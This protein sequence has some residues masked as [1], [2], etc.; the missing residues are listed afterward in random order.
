VVALTGRAP[1]PRLPAAASL[2]RHRLSQRSEGFDRR[3][4]LADDLQ[5]FM[6]GIPALDAFPQAV[7]DRSL[8]RARQAAGADALSYRPS[9]G[10]PELRQAIATYM[11][12]ACSVTPT[13]CS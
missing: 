13:R 11:R 8:A 12:A 1:D 3:R 6:P 5:P 4:T 7:W 2:P 9:A 10:E